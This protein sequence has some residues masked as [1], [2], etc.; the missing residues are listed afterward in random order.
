[1]Y[2]RK[3]L[4]MRTHKPTHTYVW[5]YTYVR[6]NTRFLTCCRKAFPPLQSD[7]PGQAEK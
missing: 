7:K 3:S 4:H 6:M 1:M 5:A 2:V